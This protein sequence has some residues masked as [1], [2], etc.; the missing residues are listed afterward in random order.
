MTSARWRRWTRGTVLALVGTGLAL[1]CG[2][3]K[4]SARPPVPVV[5][6]VAAERA[7]PLTLGAVGTVEPIES[8][9]VKAQV[10]GVITR[11]GFREGDEVRA[12][13]LLFQIDP[14]PLAA[15]LAAAEA[16]LAR[17][18]AE[19]E[20]ARVQA[21]RY[22][23]LVARDFVTREQRDAAATRAASLAAAVRADE[24]AVEQARLNLAYASVTAP[25]AGRTGSVLVKMGNVARANEAT[26]VVINQLR[27][28]RVAFAVAGERLPEIRRHAAAGE[29]P[30][31]VQPSRA[32]D[33]P[34]LAGRLTFVDNAVAPGSGTVTLK[35]EFANDDGRLWPGQFVDVELE[36][37]VEPAALTVPAGAIVTG[38]E[39]PFVFVIDGDG[40]AAKRPVRVARTA[41]DLAV[42]AAGL[43]A[44]ERVVTDGQLRLQP[45]DAVQV[46]GEAE[47]AAGAAGA[48]AAGAA[49]AAGKP[50]AAAPG[51]GAPAEGG[52]R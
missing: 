48:G 39:G 30:V 13:Q 4:K 20:N 35:A 16:Q 46:K 52:S 15:A 31:R 8:V 26:L 47:G 1:A 18:R 38:Q 22:D 3:A 44:G 14:R 51:A 27:P 37:A 28:I 32:G 5:A 43:S 7:V 49:P 10:G 12:G 33:E 40:K 11:V 24:A 23:R 6:A 34:P 25:I 50:S 42:I 45:G 21:E 29:L 17:D 36:L 9:A 2:G 19:A 41:G